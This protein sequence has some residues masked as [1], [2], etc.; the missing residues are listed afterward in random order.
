MDKPLSKPRNGIVAALDVGTT[1]VCCFIARLDANGEPKVIGLGHHAAAGTRGGA[2]VDM[3]AVENSVLSAVHSAET[4][5]GERIRQVYV[6]LSGGQPSS[7]LVDAQ[8]SVAGNEISQADIRRVLDECRQRANGVERRLIHSIPI[9]YAVDGNRGIRDPRGMYG[10][11]LAVDI[12]MVTATPGA[13]HN[14]NACLVACELEPAAFVVTPYASALSCLVDDEMNLGVTVI[15]MGGGGCTIA[16]FDDGELIHTDAIPVGGNHV[17]SDIALGLNTPV[18]HAE[19][20]KALYGSAV[21]SPSDDRQVIDVPVMGEE[22]S[23]APNQ[24]PRSLLVSVIQPRLEETFEM[25]RDRLECGALPANAARRIVLTG[26]ASQLQGMRELAAAVLDRQVRTGRPLRFA[27]LAQSTSGPAFA[28]CA[29]L[30]KYGAL[31]QLAEP[32]SEPAEMEVNAGVL[33]RMGAW[34]RENF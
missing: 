9:G 32:A 3:E 6:N 11:S 2:I 16:A 28:T 8:I 19:R 30:L 27:G 23:A 26:G 5:A 15:D 13:V 29:G 21:P 34:L 12:H 25:L 31:H 10:D 18:N 17:T 22:D 24:V 14:L 1:K 7:R 4:M 33:R 20:I